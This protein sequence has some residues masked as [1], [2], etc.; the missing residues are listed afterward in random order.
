MYMHM[1]PCIDT[2]VLAVFIYRSSF[3]IFYIHMHSMIRAGGLRKL[4]RNPCL[5]LH[6]C[7]LAAVH[8]L[9]HW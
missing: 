5:P 4:A 9:A 2:C 7:G 3:F 8:T 1:Y 6:S